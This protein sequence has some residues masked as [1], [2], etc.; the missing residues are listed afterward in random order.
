MMPNPLTL[1]SST[2]FALAGLVMLI[3][4]VGG[5]NVLN[6]TVGYLLNWDATA[7]AESWARYVAENVTD[8]EEI[9]NGVQ[10]SAASM[11]FLIRTQQIRHVFGFEILDLHG[12]VRLASDGSEISR[13]RGAAQRD[14]APNAAVSGR[15]IV[16]VKEGIPP[17]RPRIYAEAY[18]PV[19]VDQRPRAI[20]AA[21][22]DLSEQ[23]DQFRNTFL[24]AALA[25]FLLGGVGIGLPTLAWQRMT[26]EKQRADRRT[27]QYAHRLKLA[28]KAAEAVVFEYDY[29][30]K[31]YW[32]SEEMVAMIGPE[33]VHTDTALPLHLFAK[34]DHNVLRALSRRIAEREELGAIDA[35]LLTVDGDRWIRL[36]M[37]VER[38]ENGEPLRSVGLMLNIDE[39][40]K[41]ELALDQAHKAAEAAAT[42]KSNFLAAMSHEIRTPLNG[43][44]GMAQSLHGDDLTAEQ[45]E[46]VDIILDSG[47]TLMALLNDVLDLSKIDAG[48]MD[49]API[50]G[51]VRECVIR[52]TQLFKPRAEEKEIKLTMA[53]DPALLAW[54]NFDPVRVQ[55]CVSNLLSNAIKFTG[56]GGSVNLQ[57][58]T[59]AQVGG[60]HLVTIIIADTGIGMD[61]ETLGR[62]FSA[63]TQAD[64]ST[65]RQFGGSGLG[66][67]ISRQL[68]RAMGGDIAVESELGRGS[69]FRLTFVAQTAALLRAAV[70]EF[71]LVQGYSAGENADASSAIGEARILLVDDNAVNRQVV[72]LFLKPF[73]PDI[74]EAVNGL[75][76]LDALRRA[77]FDLVLLDVHMPVMDGCE[78]IKAIR[79][80]GEAWCNM[81]VIALTADAMSGDKERFL[82]IGMTDYMSKPI[83]QREL[84]SKI[85]AALASSSKGAVASSK[86]I[87]ALGR[88]EH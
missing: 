65:S 55:Q 17:V 66:L 61:D 80:G 23:H 57:L 11:A 31:E 1:R 49:I 70:P 45:C 62:L 74:R 18:L 85:T 84:V 5:G 10:P 29:A 63:F 88:S 24:I 73:A 8:I 60:T 59:T 27:H 16:S 22:V 46:K 20:V 52:A 77:P 71:S 72:K 87:T 38:Q 33:R 14:P 44:L 28:L 67:A 53:M 6:S 51:D 56:P 48:K 81:P 75:D 15:P 68:A 12:N 76:A 47:S 41:Q 2:G 79:L 30:K 35:R 69:S 9:A 13:I 32:A 25:L 4:V 82:A 42:A 50:D 19:I 3:T 86:P 34:D 64:G 58:S 7:A 40:K 39:K 78:T 54:L 36:Y 21:Y 83:D 26:K 43:V 37:E